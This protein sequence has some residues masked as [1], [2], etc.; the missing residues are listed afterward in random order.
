[1]NFGKALSLFKTCSPLLPK[2]KVEQIY[3][4]MDDIRKANVFLND[5]MTPLFTLSNVVINK[6]INFFEDHSV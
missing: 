3:S 2:D 6:E 5:F 1:M 4:I